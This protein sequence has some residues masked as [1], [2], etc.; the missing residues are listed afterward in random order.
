[1]IEEEK[2][3]RKIVYQELK[4]KN[5]ALFYRE[6]SVV[7]REWLSALTKAYKERGI[8]GKP[9]RQQHHRGTQNTY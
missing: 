7:H 6:F 8:S 4:K 5:I 1:M 9:Q 3:R 2:L